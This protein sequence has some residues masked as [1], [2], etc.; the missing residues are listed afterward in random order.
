MKELIFLVEDDSE[1]GFTARAL[2]ESIFTQG[3]TLDELKQNVRE[4]VLTHFDKDKIP[5]VVRLHYVK[6]EILSIAS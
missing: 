2:G 1:S 4:A 5:S 6:D 3:E